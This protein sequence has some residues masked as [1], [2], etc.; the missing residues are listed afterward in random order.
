MQS[1][2]YTSFGNVRLTDVEIKQFIDLCRA[3]KPEILKEIQAELNYG[4]ESTPGAIA[5]AQQM[6]KFLSQDNV[7]IVPRHRT[8]SYSANNGAIFKPAGG[9]YSAKLPY[10]YAET[11]QIIDNNSAHCT[12][13]GYGPVIVEGIDTNQISVGK[14]NSHLLMKAIGNRQV[15]GIV[16]NKEVEVYQAVSN[17][18]FPKDII[19]W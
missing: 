16:G 4:L 2:N 15:P 12:F 17:D 1:H 3:K 7:L 14:W 11:H 19:L 10:A 8:A 5:E 13:N 6:F 18:G 9:S